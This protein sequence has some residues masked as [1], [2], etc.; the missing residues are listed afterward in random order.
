LPWLRLDDGFAQHPKVSRLTRGDR[1]TWL[2]ILLY[3]ARYRTGGN[4][5]ASIAEV[6]PKAT[7]P[8]LGRCYEIHL[9]DVRADGEEGYVVHDWETYNPKDPTG[10]DRVRR[11][12]DRNPSVT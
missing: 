5:P 2:E 6:V 12:R 10:A 7:P 8:F 3:C 4:L 11:Y 9:L 1:W